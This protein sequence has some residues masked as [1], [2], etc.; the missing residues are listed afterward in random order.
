ML[1]A[2]PV[3][4]GFGTAGADTLTVNGGTL[5]VN[6]SGDGSIPTVRLRL[7]AVTVYVSGP[8]GVG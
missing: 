2:A 6:A 5:T 4:G 1:Q 3:D 8:T 7:T